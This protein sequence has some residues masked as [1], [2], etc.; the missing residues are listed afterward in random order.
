VRP[1]HGGAGEDP[2]APFRG[3]KMSGNGREWGEIAFG[4]FLETKAVIHR[5][6]VRGSR[7]KETREEQA[8]NDRS[9]ECQP[10]GAGARRSL[11]AI[12]TR[13]ARESAFIFRIT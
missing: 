5:E 13:S 9:V 10:F 6:R 2:E 12:V 11:A 8:E 1:R 3:Y 4:D 7:E